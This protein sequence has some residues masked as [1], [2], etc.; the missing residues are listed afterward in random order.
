MNVEE[1][2]KTTVRDIIDF[3]KPGIVFKDI[4]PLLQNAELCKEITDEFAKRVSH[5]KIEGV[6]AVE[7]RG[8]LFGM[9]IAQKL[10]VPFIPIR[11]KGKLPYDTFEESYNLEYGSATIEMHKDAIKIS[12][13]IL[14]HDDLLATGG[15]IEAASKLILKAGGNVTAYSFLIELAFLNGSEKIKRFGADLIG[16]VQY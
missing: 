13:N 6:A 14:L 11:K 8:F 4:T 12:Q 5:L 15:T 1:K 2:I 16:L 7:S 10:Q 9:L 3:P